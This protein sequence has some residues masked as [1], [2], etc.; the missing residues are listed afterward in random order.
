[1]F[2]FL[3]EAICVYVLGIQRQ[4][5]TAVKGKLNCKQYEGNSK[6]Y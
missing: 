5:R 4:L 6:D 2:L 3:N 1:M